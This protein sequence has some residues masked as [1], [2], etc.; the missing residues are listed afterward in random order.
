MVTDFAF[1]FHESGCLTLASSK[2][3]AESIEY[4]TK[5]CF[6]A[7]SANCRNCLSS[8]IRSNQKEDLSLKTSCSRRMGP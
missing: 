4:L 8:W 1:L 3:N 2:T 5:Q 6:P 7:K